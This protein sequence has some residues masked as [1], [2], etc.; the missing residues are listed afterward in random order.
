MPRN[1][2]N[3]CLDA[4]LLSQLSR[5]L[6]ADLPVSQALVI[7][8]AMKHLPPLSSAAIDQ[9]TLKRPGMAFQA[10]G[11]ISEFP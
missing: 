3:E 11:R 7:R 6:L 1:D 10:K 5:A 8:D 9:L 4:N 2:V